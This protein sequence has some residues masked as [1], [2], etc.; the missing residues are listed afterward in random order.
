MKTKPMIYECSNAN[1]H[2]FIKRYQL[3]VK[4]FLKT[5]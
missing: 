4:K 5:N 3:Y 2:S 1:A